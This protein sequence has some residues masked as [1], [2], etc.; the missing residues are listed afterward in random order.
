MDKIKLFFEPQSVALIGATDRENAVGRTVLENL[1]TAKDTRKIYPVNPKKEA[2]L[3]T[4]CYPNVKAIP[5]TP[6]LA[7]IVTPA[8]IVPEMVEECGKAGI[9]AIIIISAGF[10]E[11]GAEGKEREARIMENALKYGIRI[12]GPNCLG[13]IK[14]AAGLNATFATKLAKP[15][16]V[17]FLSQ[18]GALG[19]AVLDWAASHNIGFSAFVSVGSMLDVDFGDLIDYFGADPKTRSILIYLESL[20]NSLKNAKKF[21]SAARGFARTKPIIIIKPGKFAESMAAAKS[22]TGA[23]VSEDLYYDA[24]FNRAGAV[25]VEEIE[26]LFNCASI[27]NTA[28]LPKAPNV[29]IVTNAG[30]P[31]VLAT[32]ALISR[33]G[34]LAQMT[35]ETF[36]AL[37]QFLPPYWSKSNPVDILGDAAP[38]TYVKTIETV[39]KDPNVSGAV[40]IYTPQGIASPMEVAKAIVKYAKKANKPIVTSMI[41]S[42]EVAKAR[43]LFYDNGIPTYEFP[44]EAIKTYLYMYQYAKG[45][46]MLYETPEDLPLELGVPKN[47]LK[48]LT[49]R[50]AKEGRTLLSEED[51]KKLLTAYGITST[52]PHLARTAEEAVMIASGLG[53]PVVMKITS[54]DISHKSDVGGV[55]LR[56]ASADE[57]KK[58]WA[59]MMDTV[60]K[61]QPDAKIEGISIQKM[62]TGYHYE[63]IVGSKK[64][65]VLGPVILF[66]LGGTEAEFFKDV[67]VGVPPLNQSLARRILE[68]TKTYKLLSQGFRSKPPANLRLLDETLV[69]VSNMII[70]FPE[71]KELDINPLVVCPDGVVALDARIILDEEVVKTGIEEHGH[72]IISPYPTKYVQPWRCRD[73]RQVLL[74]P[75]RPEDE[76]MERELIAGLSPESSRYRFFYTI[77]DITHEM[78]TR[79]CNIDYDREMAIIAEYTADKKRRNVGVGRLIISPS[80][81]TGEFAIVVA[82]DFQ[83]VGLGIKISDILIGVAREKGL[84]S[85][86]AVVL[87][88]NR[89]MLNLARKLG[90][91]IK[92]ISPEES[93]ITLDLTV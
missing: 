87:N 2:C 39:L 89:G 60:K 44:E 28:V 46:E 64:D 76:P 75:I 18:S 74:R 49:H 23:M 88:E 12:I 58:V 35:K 45:L 73:G 37:S 72:L 10:K 21:M 30:G 65:P 36:A 91:T 55:R 6:D 11:I 19:S 33:G 71:I 63:L 80:G 8:Q 4:K 93:N 1:L 14:P 27:L 9:K 50:Q 70:D 5:E 54:P 92:M 67:A 86:Y 85:I 32:D 15:G 42:E 41:G 7:V 77:R 78:L 17:A 82:D 68:G 13:V 43:K 38:E 40:V 51:S 3:D 84:R 61:A 62:I 57:V 53:Y 29:A 66:G 59:E 47:Y 34:K 20:G 31:A 79:F 52:T 81:D 25:R 83:R 90:F 56:I 16:R 48:I 24:V 26:D 69:K 22:H